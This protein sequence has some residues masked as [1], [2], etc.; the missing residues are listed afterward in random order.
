M[1]LPNESAHQQC[2]APQPLI[3]DHLAHALELARAG[4]PVFPLVERGK[5][6]FR[7]SHAKD[8]A[9]CD[10]SQIVDWWTR[11]PQANI[12][13]R[14]PEGIVVLDVDP[15]NGGDR[16]IA[17]LVGRDGP[18][19]KTL[20]CRTGSGGWHHWLAYAGPSRGKLGD[21]I[22]VKTHSGYLVMPPSVHPNGRRYVWEDETVRTAPAPQWLRALLRP[23]AP[24]V[25]APMQGSAKEASLLWVVAESKPGTINDRLYWAACRAAEAGLLD[26]QLADEL[27]DAAARAAGPLATPKGL[28]ESRRTVESAKR[29][30]GLK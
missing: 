30:G 8:D 15:R 4:V 21:G 28:R 29:N 2:G 18:L 27:V 23:P 7:G 17:D 13:A 10:E 19:P 1:K 22:D 12:G 16:T 14:P 20:T 6:P 3:L 9:T 24:K 11:R 25:F 26:G 5:E